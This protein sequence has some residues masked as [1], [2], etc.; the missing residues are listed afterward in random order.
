M[1]NYLLDDIICHIVE[2]INIYH[3]KIL[4][5]SSKEFYSKRL[6]INQNNYFLLLYSKSNNSKLYTDLNKYNL[7]VNIYSNYS[8]NKKINLILYKKKAL[9]IEFIHNNIKK[10]KNLVNINNTLNFITNINLN[11]INNIKHFKYLN[12]IKY[13]ENNI[14]FTYDYAYNESINSVITYYFKNIYL[15]FDKLYIV[16]YLSVVFLYHIINKNNKCIRYILFDIDKF[17]R[18]VKID[19][20]KY[21]YQYIISTFKNI[22]VTFDYYLKKYKFNKDIIIYYKL[23]LIY[24][25]FKIQ[26]Y[27]KDYYVLEEFNLLL[28][29][30]IIK[31]ISDI[32][33]IDI[34]PI[35]KSIKN[36]LINKYTNI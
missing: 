16:L 5:Q 21:E 9:Y 32:K 30:T 33:N 14:L 28:N 13:I 3:I 2:K 17:F 6:T 24:L 11:D 15:I 12:S 1:I 4:I 18:N 8:L 34:K 31:N 10:N 7:N 27:F 20:N 35:P 36:L 26:K 25:Y 23:L 22:I 19:V 29:N